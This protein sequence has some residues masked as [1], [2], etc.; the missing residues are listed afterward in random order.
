LSKTLIIAG[1]ALIAMAGS[2]LAQDFG[3]PLQAPRQSSPKFGVG[4]VITPEV[5]HPPA[6]GGE[7][8]KR[9]KKQTATVKGG[10]IEAPQPSAGEQKQEA[11]VFAKGN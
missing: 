5:G 2:A 4:P 6:W 9:V 11:P 10:V 8:A 3:Q 7:P 1:A